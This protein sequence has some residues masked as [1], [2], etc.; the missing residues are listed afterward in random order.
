MLAHLSESES[1]IFFLTSSQNIPS[2]PRTFLLSSCSGKLA[3]WKVLGRFWEVVH[4]PPSRHFLEVCKTCF[5]SKTCSE[6]ESVDI[7]DKKLGTAHHAM[8]PFRP[9]DMWKPHTHTYSNSADKALVTTFVIFYS[10]TSYEPTPSHPSRFQSRGAV[11][12]MV[13][14]IVKVLHKRD[15]V[16]RASVV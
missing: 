7:F 14:K 1:A 12:P 6:D 5:A 8:A 2:I 13:V 3:S 10:K 4:F 15:R 11:P 16:F 9:P